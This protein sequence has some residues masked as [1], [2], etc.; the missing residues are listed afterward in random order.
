MMIASELF[1]QCVASIRRGELIRRESQNDK[2]FHFQNWFA[3]R[4]KAAGVNFDDPRRNSYPD[5]CLVNYPI[6]F[7]LKGLA[8]PGRRTNYDS[9]SQIPR[10]E[11]KGRGVYYVFGRY[12]KKI[13]GNTFPV[14]DLVLCHGTFLNADSTY[15]HKNKH[16]PGFGSYGDILVRDRK[17]YVVPTP[18]ALAEGTA[19]TRTLI[20]PKDQPAG[21]GLVPVGNLRR[22][23]CAEIICAYRFDLET[24]ELVTEKR[25]NPNAGVFHDF[26]AYRVAG[27]PL[28]PVTLRDTGEVLAELEASAT[29][30]DA[31]SPSAEQT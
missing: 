19:H 28:D 16:F 25:P 5:F 21:D 8:Y 12:P 3:A 14:L 10:G 6:G 13:D 20:L 2:E 1:K 11:H 18:Y 24:N 23:E 31:K 27:D 22:R 4:L 7:E 26:V 15:V 9:N 17:M 30:L 29:A